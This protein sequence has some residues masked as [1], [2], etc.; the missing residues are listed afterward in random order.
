MSEIGRLFADANGALQTIEFIA[1]MIVAQDVRDDFDR[2]AR[3][4]ATFLEYSLKLCFDPGRS[5]GDK[6]PVYIELEGLRAKS[7]SDATKWLP[8]RPAPAWIKRHVI[9]P[10]RRTTPFI[11]TE[12]FADGAEPTIK[13]FGERTGKGGRPSIVPARRSPQTVLCGV[14]AVTHPTALAARNEMR[15]W[16][17]LQLE[18]SALRRPDELHGNPPVSAIGEHLPSALARI[19]SHA[20]IARR[21]AELIP[22]A[23]AVEVESDEVRQTRTLVVK[24]RDRQDYSASSLSDGTLR[25]L[26]LAIMANDPDADGLICMEEP[27]NGIHPKRIPAM[28]SL[29]RAL[30]NDDDE[31]GEDA[32]D[33]GGLRQVLINTHSPLVVEQLPDD[34]LLVAETLRLHGREFVNF[35]P[36]PKT[37]RAAAGDMKPGDLVSRGELAAHLGRSSNAKVVQRGRRPAVAGHLT[38]VRIPTG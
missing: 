33:V 13:L 36:V 14:N 29:V 6:D 3:P 34:T 19:G 12:P 30:S 17:L 26:A 15:S 24:L 23:L 20:E 4:T 21:L 38:A 32:G 16:R 5:G 2:L 35:K 9:G 18:P 37:W 25:F 27:E 31:G 1:D 11:E 22:G 8:F 7:S 28:L 10:G